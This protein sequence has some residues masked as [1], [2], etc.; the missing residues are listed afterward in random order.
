M[1]TKEKQAK[2]D[3]IAEEIISRKCS[4]EIARTCLNPVPGN[5]NP[6]AELMFIG[7]APGA[8]EDKAGQPFIGASGKFLDEMLVSIDLRREDVF[9]TNIVKF[10]P[11]DNRDP[12]AEE[13][14]ICLPYL[15]RQIEVIKPK[16]LVFLGRHSMNVFLPGLKISEVHG[17]LQ[18][19]S[20]VAMLPLYHPAAALY[21]G[22]M[23][24]IVKEDFSRIP[25]ILKT[26]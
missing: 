15:N 23:R 19:K 9:V 26:I 12:N 14:D 4:L 1:D 8:Q 22:S 7:E 2:L 24:S 25:E 20:G 13:I 6:D 16:L 10:R 18:N 5:G 11:P 17:R 3:S 21:N